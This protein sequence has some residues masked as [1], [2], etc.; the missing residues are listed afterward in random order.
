MLHDG[1]C[2]NYSKR[3]HSPCCCVRLQNNRIQKCSNRRLYINLRFSSTADGTKIK[4]QADSSDQEANLETHTKILEK[5]SCQPEKLIIKLDNCSYDG[6]MIWKI[7][8]I[9]QHIGNAHVLGSDY[10]I[11]SPSLYSSRHGYKI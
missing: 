10:C 8:Y 5:I 2:K 7:D 1:S 3:K 9:K 4:T 11:S 6:T